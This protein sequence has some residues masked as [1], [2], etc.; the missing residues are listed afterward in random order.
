MNIIKIISHAQDI[1]VFKK[2][3]VGVQRICNIPVHVLYR[4]W[5]GRGFQIHACLITYIDT[6]TSVSSTMFSCVYNTGILCSI[7]FLE[8]GGGNK[9][10][11]VYISEEMSVD[12]N[13]HCIFLFKFTYASVWWCS[14]KKSAVY[15]CFFFFFV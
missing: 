13:I 6:L 1:M 14:A 5:N 4:Y 2:I 10:W 15:I 9:N 3:R 7:F 8:G 11:F 12:T